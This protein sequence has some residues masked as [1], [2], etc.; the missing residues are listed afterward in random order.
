MSTIVGPIPFSIWGVPPMKRIAL[1]IAALFAVALALVWRVPAF[2][3]TLENCARLEAERKKQP[4]PD[5]NAKASPE[6]VACLKAK[7]DRLEKASKAALDEAEAK[8]ATAK[9][10]L[11]EVRKRAWRTPEGE[12]IFQDGQVWRYEDGTIVP[13][14]IVA[15]KVPPPQ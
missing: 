14:G 11:E 2:E 13:P 4:P 5:P 6:Q 7:L 8:R 1:S 12:P 3:P 15:K 9:A 10:K